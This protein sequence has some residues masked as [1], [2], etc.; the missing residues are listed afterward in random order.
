MG[1]K[2]NFVGVCD[3]L[4]L[5]V[6]VCGIHGPFLFSLLLASMCSTKHFNLFADRFVK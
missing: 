5:G 6:L 3:E 4:N 2:G 1:A